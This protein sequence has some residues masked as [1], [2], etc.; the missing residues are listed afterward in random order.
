MLD[1]VEIIESLDLGGPEAGLLLDLPQRGE[2]NRLVGIHST[3]H[4]LPQSREDAIG[5]TAD[6]QQLELVGPGDPKHPDL[7]EIRTK[8]HGER[9][10][11]T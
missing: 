6:Q 7:Y 8:A 4:A 2:R 3:A 10:S 11:P 1:L 5:R 9:F